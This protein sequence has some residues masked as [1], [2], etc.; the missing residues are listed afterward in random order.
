MV[1]CL[2]VRRGRNKTISELDHTARLKSIELAEVSVLESPEATKSSEAR[3]YARPPGPE[4]RSADCGPHPDTKD[5]RVRWSDR[6]LITD[7]IADEIAL[8]SYDLG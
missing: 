2:R 6:A 8:A 1:L 7:E 3:A 5:R 4:E